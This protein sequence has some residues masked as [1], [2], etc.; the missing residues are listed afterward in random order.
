MVI[1]P[2]TSTMLLAACWRK[3]C[4]CS[5]YMREDTK[6]C[7]NWFVSSISN[8]SNVCSS[9]ISAPGMMSSRIACRPIPVRM[10]GS[11]IA[12]CGCMY[13]N[14]VEGSFYLIISKSTRVQC[15][16]APRSTKT[17][18]MGWKNLLLS[19]AKK[20]VPAE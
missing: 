4:V 9:F 6:K 18:Q 11:M 17:C 20:Y 13:L 1:S 19:C 5:K 14:F 3:N 10:F 8:S 15:A 16:I 12:N 7:T 2:F